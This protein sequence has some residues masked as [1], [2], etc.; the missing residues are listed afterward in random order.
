MP[1]DRYRMILHFLEK[2]KLPVGGI[3]DGIV[4]GATITRAAAAVIS[5]PAAPS[6]ALTRI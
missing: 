3:A 2:P 6:P 4:G 5:A 1:F